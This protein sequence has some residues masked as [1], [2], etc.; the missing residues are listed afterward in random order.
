MMYTVGMRDLS[1]R[2]SKIIALV[3]AGE[4]S[5]LLIEDTGFPSKAHSSSSKPAR[6]AGVGRD[7]RQL[8]SDPTTRGGTRRHREASI[9]TGDHTFTTD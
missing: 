5:R 4:R 3:R 9:N 8:F 6:Q 1:Q 2:T 7:W